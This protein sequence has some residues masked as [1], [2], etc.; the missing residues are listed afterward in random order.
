MRFIS[1]PIA[2]AWLVEPEA[3]ADER[4]FFAR[5]WCRDELEARGLRADFIQCNNSFSA[6][7]GTLRGL[8]YQAAPHA[9]AKLLSCTRGR[10]FDVLVD[11]RPG[12]P[13]FRQWFGAE[14][15]AENRRMMYVPEECA[16]GYLTL[17]DASE[18]IYP[19]TAAYHPESERGLRWNDPAVG[20]QW[21]IEPLAMSDK[22]RRWPDLVL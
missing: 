11:L 5:L 1:V 20:I 8:H 15:T 2:G 18:V 14:L 4:G 13:T 7:R 17:E 21:P 3:R 9:E 10:V 6:A 19:V 12:S 16:H 22:D